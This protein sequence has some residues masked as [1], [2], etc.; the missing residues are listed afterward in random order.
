M[1][2][3]DSEYL[4]GFSLLNAL[5]IAGIPV[6]SAGVI[7][8]ETGPEYEVYASRTFD[9]YRKLTFR[10]GTLAGLLLVGCVEKPGVYTTLIR[11]HAD[12]HEF[13]EAMLSNSFGYS[14]Y[15]QR[16]ASPS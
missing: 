10:N 9:T 2:G 7:H 4:G 13:K 14:Q 6:I 5:D 15:I 11:E 8:A 3:A 12:L 1:A 16:N